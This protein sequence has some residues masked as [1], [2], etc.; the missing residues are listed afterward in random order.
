M[1]PRR[2][3]RVLNIGEAE[4]L[5]KSPLSGTSL[6]LLEEQRCEIHKIVA[7][8]QPGVQA[9]CFDLR[10]RHVLRFEEIDESPIWRDEIVFGSAGDPEKA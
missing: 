3:G 10:D 7:P 1:A 9:G 5:D 8:D 2:K 6:L 4:W